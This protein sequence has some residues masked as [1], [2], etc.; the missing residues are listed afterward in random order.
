[1]N[2]KETRAEIARLQA[3]HRQYRKANIQWPLCFTVGATFVCLKSPAAFAEVRIDEPEAGGIPLPPADAVKI[4][5]QDLGA[6]IEC[7]WYEAYVNDHYKEELR[8]VEQKV[9]DETLAR[10]KSLI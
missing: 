5:F 7:G 9:F 8:V 1:M 3:A 2:T 4:R 10:A 6:G